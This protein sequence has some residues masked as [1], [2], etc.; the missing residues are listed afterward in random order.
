M[1]FS[2][3]SVRYHDDVYSGLARVLFRIL[4][5]LWCLSVTMT[6]QLVP[7]AAVPYAV[8]CSGAWLLP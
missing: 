5:F 1:L 4:C 3:M 7:D 6:T 8:A 2:L